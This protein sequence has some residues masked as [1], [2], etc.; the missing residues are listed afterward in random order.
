M[1]LC[2]KCQEK[3]V[4]QE[5]SYACIHKHSFDISKEGYVNLLLKNSV[6]HGDS[7]EMVIARR[8]FLHNDYYLPMAN[9]LIELITNKHP[10]TLID[11]GC[12][13]GYYTSLL[14]QS[15]Q[16]ELYANDVSKEA[17]KLAAKANKNITYFIASTASLP[18]P[19]NSFDIATCIFSYIDN[20]EIHRI[21]KK[22]GYLYTVMPAKNHLFSL[23]KVVYDTPYVNQENI[24]ILEDF[25]LVA[26]Y[27]IDYTIH[28]DSSEKIKELFTMTPYYFKTS[29]QDFAKLDNISSLDIEVSFLINEYQAK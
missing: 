10:H 21:L 28:L 6:N 14:Q 27:P 13:E 19:T 23:K 16:C 24:P 17:I 20:K 12:G 25:T 9:K 18:L 7:K 15:L 29:I 5:H 26:T 8:N 2:P 11:L 22:D 4:K 3:L 1:L